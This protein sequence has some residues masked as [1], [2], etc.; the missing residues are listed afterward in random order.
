MNRASA[1][2]LLKA[3]PLYALAATGQATAQASPLDR[4]MSHFVDSDWSR[5]FSE[6]VPLAD[7]GHPEA[8]RIA[9]MLHQRGARLFS[10]SFP[11]SA[12]Q[13]SRWLALSTWDP[14]PDTSGDSIAVTCA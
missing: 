2:T 5:A 12:A 1:S 11:A 13:R 9:L 6:L 14:V 10:G 4:A 7:Q 3:F 8:A